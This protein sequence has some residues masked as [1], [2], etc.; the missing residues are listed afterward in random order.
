MAKVNGKVNAYNDFKG[1]GF[2]RRE[3]GKD[4]YFSI[5]D[6]TTQV[7]IDSIV[8]GMSLLFDVVKTPKG[9]RATAI[10]LC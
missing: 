1:F 8:I 6:F 4:L 9:P 3:K 7:D 2:I 5:D 10:E